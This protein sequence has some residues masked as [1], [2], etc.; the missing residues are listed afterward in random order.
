MLV[1][2]SWTVDYSNVAQAKLIEYSLARSKKWK[3]EYSSKLNQWYQPFEL[4][5]L[6]KEQL[7]SFIDGKNH[8]IKVE[9]RGA[10]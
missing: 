4:C 10:R 2:N 5:I 1:V 3:W 6:E 7:T 8:C 9:K